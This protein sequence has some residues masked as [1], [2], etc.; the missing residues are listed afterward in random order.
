[1][2]K[3]SL[4]P[5]ASGTGNFTIASPDSSTDRTLTLPDNTGTIITTASTFGGTGPTFSAYQSS[6]QTLSST[7]NTKITF[8]S[9]DWDTTSGMFASSRFTPTIAGYYLVDGAITMTSSF[10]GGEVLIYKNGTSFKAGFGLGSGSICNRF[11][12]SGLVYCNGTTD[13]IEIYGY[14]TTGQTLTTG[15]NQT[16]FQAAMIR[17][18]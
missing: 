18:A 2:S 15:N 1:M 3:I 14:I 12:V 7:T 6:A 17:S 5:H 4:S 16:Y 11:T 13:Y 10:C 8:T 9:N